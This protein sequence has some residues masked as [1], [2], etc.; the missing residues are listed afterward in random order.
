MSVCRARGV[1]AQGRETWRSWQHPDL[2]DLSR[3]DYANGM[4]KTEYRLDDTKSF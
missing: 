3:L 2:E 4:R 1:D